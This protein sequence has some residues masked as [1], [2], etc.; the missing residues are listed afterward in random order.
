LDDLAG[1]IDA[2]LDGGPCL[3]GVESTVLDLTGARPVILRPGGVSREALESVLGTSIAETGW[4]G[5]SAPPS[6]GMK[7]R[8]YAPRA[9][10]LLITGPPGRR[11]ALIRALAAYY[12]KRGFKV[13]LLHSHSKDPAGREAAL[14]RCLYLALRGFD[15]RGAGVILAEET[16]RRGI[17]AAVMNRL[18]KAAVRVIR[19]GGMKRCP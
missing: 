5:V 7:Y 8:H 19:I 11:A 17:G 18:R 9:P 2:V 3:V 16:S 1:M 15:A 4:R 10:L 6:P 12:R 13:G 14:A